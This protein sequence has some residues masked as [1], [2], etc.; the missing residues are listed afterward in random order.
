MSIN[1]SFFFAATSLAMGYRGQEKEKRGLS[2][3]L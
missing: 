1:D 3:N 2:E